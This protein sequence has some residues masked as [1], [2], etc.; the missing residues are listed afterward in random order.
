M[1][2]EVGLPDGVSYR[3]AGQQDEQEKEMAFLSKAL[4]IAV[5]LILII[6]VTQFNSY[7]APVIILLS[8]VFSLVGCFPWFGSFGYVFRNYDDHDWYYLPWPALW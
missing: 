1:N 4:L 3:F 6:I 8:V 5:F 2:D 7:S